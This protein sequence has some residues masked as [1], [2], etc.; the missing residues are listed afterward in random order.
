MKPSL[1]QLTLGSVLLVLDVH[2]YN[3]STSRG[4]HNIGILILKHPCRYLYLRDRRHHGKGCLFS[5]E[6]GCL[7]LPGT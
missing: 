6:G 2:V 4:T 5:H 3:M 1:N 7:Y